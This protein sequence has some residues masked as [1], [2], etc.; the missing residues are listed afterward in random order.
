MIG[1]ALLLALQSSSTN[2]Y[3]LGTTVQCD[4]YQQPAPASPPPPQGFDA[5][6]AFR[7]FQMGQEARQQEESAR[8]AQADSAQRSDPRYELAVRVSDLIGAGRCEDAYRLAILAGDELMAQ[9][10]RELCRR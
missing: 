9:R 7:A 10:A 1:L 2:C 3:N 4:T 8:S 5:G 6:A